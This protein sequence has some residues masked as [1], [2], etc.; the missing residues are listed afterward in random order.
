MRRWRRRSYRK[1]PWQQRW[2][3]GQDW[4]YYGRTRQRGPS[5]TTNTDPIE[6]GDAYDLPRNGP[7]T[8]VTGPMGDPD[9]A[10]DWSDK[11]AGGWKEP[12]TSTRLAMDTFGEEEPH[13]IAMAP[14]SGLSAFW[15]IG[16][17][18]P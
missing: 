10:P 12:E 16:P 3:S 15:T 9:Q 11:K 17:H 7:T 8:L 6:E 2:T 4:V 18:N 5:R 14:D 1:Y 13:H